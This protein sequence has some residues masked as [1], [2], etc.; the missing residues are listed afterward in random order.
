MWLLGFCAL[1]R[2]KMVSMM[3]S[4]GPETSGGDICYIKVEHS[5]GLAVVPLQLEDP[6][7]DIITTT[8]LDI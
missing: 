4:T 3:Y 1:N 5:E 8:F 2:R 7:G 6:L